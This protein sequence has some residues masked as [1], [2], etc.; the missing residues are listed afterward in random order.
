M[1][2]YL[3]RRILQAIPTFLGITIVTFVIIK[4]APGDPVM[5]MT[6]NPRIKAETRAKIRHQ[7]GLD[8]PIVVQYVI[9]LVGNDWMQWFGTEVNE[10]ALRRGVIRLDFGRS[11]LEKRPATEMILE[12]VPATVQLNVAAL[13]L[14]Y[15]IGVPVGVYSAV[16]QKSMFDNMARVMAVVF[17]AVPGFW[18]SLLILMLFAVKFRQWGLPSIAMGGMYTVTPDNRFKYD[19]LDRLKH[20]LPP[21]IVLATGGIA[22]ISRFLRTEVLEVIHQDYIRTARAKGLGERVVTFVHA[23]RNALI[24]IATMLGP[25]ITGLLGGAVITETIWSWPGLGRMFVEANFKRDYPVV[26]AGFVIGAIA[27]ILGN[28]LSDVLYALFDPRIRL[29]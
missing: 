27:V 20:L 16:K 13:L 4:L 6:F 12:R 1:T 26:L 28:L 19:L 3:I 2:R 14:S 17:D 7:L 9:W 29:R 15:G 11:Y 21:A 8:Q 25:Q 5:Q 23:G 18:L 22:V 10:A 24:P